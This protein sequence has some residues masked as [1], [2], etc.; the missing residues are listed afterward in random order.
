[1]CITTE[2]CSYLFFKGYIEEKVYNRLF[3]NHPLLKTHSNQEND[4]ENLHPKNPDSIE[5]LVG[6]IIH[7]IPV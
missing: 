2:A 4:N 5:E 3:S 1:M 7:Y 6:R